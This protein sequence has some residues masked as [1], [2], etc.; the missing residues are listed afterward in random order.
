MVVVPHGAVSRGLRTRKRPKGLE[1]KAKMLE[2][3]RTR[4]EQER[5][6]ICIDVLRTLEEY[7]IEKAVGVESKISFLKMKAV[8][9]R[10]HDGSLHWRQA[11]EG[12]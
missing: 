3:Y 5:G 10:V 8:D 12:Y 4:V 1:T 2:N 7:M 11:Q 9:S 6:E